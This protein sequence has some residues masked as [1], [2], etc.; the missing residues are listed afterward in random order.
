MAAYI[1]VLCK[2]GTHCTP[3]SAILL[4]ILPAQL[5]WLLQG[6]QFTQHTEWLTF[7]Q[8]LRQQP[9]IFGSLSPLHQLLILAQI[10]L[11]CTR[12]LTAEQVPLG[13]LRQQ[14]HA[15]IAEAVSELLR[16]ILICPLCTV[17]N[18]HKSAWPLLAGGLFAAPHAAML[19]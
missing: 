17:W 7:L 16:Y 18:Q 15:V 9:G 13:L 14:S 12:Q 19:S 8:Q 5:T 6:R 4:W 11:A 10:R 3:L 2:V 1:H